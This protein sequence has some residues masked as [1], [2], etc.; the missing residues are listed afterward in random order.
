MLQ[1][2]LM[3]AVLLAIGLVLAGVPARAQPVTAPTV[4]AL[5]DSLTY[6]FLREMPYTTTL[7]QRLGAAWTVTNRGLNG[8]TTTDMR[9]RIERDVLDARPTVLVLLGGVNDL[10]ADV[11]IATIVDNL[12]AMY[13]AAHAAGVRVVAVTVMPFSAAPQWSPTRQAALDAL[14]TWIRT[15]AQVEVVVDAYQA[16][17]D[18][19]QPTRLAPAYDRGDGLHGSAAGYAALGQAIFAGVSW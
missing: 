13:A 15:E 2:A 9:S 16:L 18:A 3:K 17:G 6:G 12:R 1:S 4:I 19:Q 7:A 11:P 5:G 10:M 8:S 14:N